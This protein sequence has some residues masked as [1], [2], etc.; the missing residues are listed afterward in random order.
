[1]A[2]MIVGQF[3]S[4]DLDLG[5]AHTFLD[6]FTNG[7]KEHAKTRFNQPTTEGLIH[8]QM[9]IISL[10]KRLRVEKT[11]EQTLVENLTEIA[12]SEDAI[13]EIIN[14]DKQDKRITETVEQVYWK[15]ETIGYQINVFGIL[16]EIIL[17]WKTIVMPGFAVITPLLV[18]IMPYILL[19]VLFG[20]VIDVSEYINILKN[21]VMQNTPTINIP[22]NEGS[23]IT[24]LAKYAYIL[25]SAGVFISNIW[26]Q[27]QSAIHLRAVAED[28]RER[29]SKMIDYVRA[30]TKLASLIKD[31]E[32]LMYAKSVGFTDDTIALGAYGM[33]YNDTR[34]ITRLRAWV[35]SIDL[36]IGLA[37]KKG[38]CFPKII[39][40]Y[41]FELAIEGLY[42][43]GVPF[44]KRV[45][46][47]ID[48]GPSTNNMLITGPNRGGKSTLC[49]SIGFAVMCAQSWGVAFA[50]SMSFVPVSR[51]ETALAP[52]DTL[53]RLSLFEAEIEFAKH[54]LAVADKARMVSEEAPLFII[55]DEIFHS[56]NAHD[57]AEASLIF[58]KQLYTKGDHVG[59]LIST[60]YR[61]LPDKL[62]VRNYCMEAF[63]NGDE[64]IKYTYR[65]IPGTSVISS[66]KEI[67]KERGLLTM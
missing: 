15:P 38:I 20:I 41:K 61:E 8:I 3:V 47:N 45:L 32:G 51:F 64:G 25:M 12:K 55:M 28:L 7:G 46:N 43:P 21:M 22:G 39:K 4:Q 60:H 67:L 52:A 40:G 10:R 37:R 56:T 9:P 26:N 54:L 50:K 65:C 2:G 57:G 19:R 16:I 23:P 66:V 11:L 6:L 59:S 17:L 36:R 5:E 42:H 34:N 49:K 53:G 1:M 44:G 18:V 29:G 31:D 48:F 33:L 24:F 30:C 13:V 62:N 63:D 14:S 27:I 35:S 58:L